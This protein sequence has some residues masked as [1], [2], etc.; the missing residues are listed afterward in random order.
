MS[1]ES[2]WQ[3][4]GAIGTLML[5]LFYYESVWVRWEKSGRNIIIGKSVKINRNES[6]IMTGALYSFAKQIPEGFNNCSDH[7][8]NYE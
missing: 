7:P 1:A 3:V 8:V 4:D 5:L 2:S 6:F